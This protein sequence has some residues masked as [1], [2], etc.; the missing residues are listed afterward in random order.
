MVALRE[1]LTTWGPTNVTI[2]TFDTLMDSRSLFLTANDNTPYT[3][4]WINLHDG[5]LVAEIPPHVLGMINDFWF[6]YV[7]D[8]SIVGLDKG[9]GG[10]Y[11]ILP[12]GYDGEFPKG[13][14]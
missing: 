3:W 5:P 2:P 6:R 1:G 11:L 13:R 9:K 10:K 12:P 8:I 7:V 14:G 4:M